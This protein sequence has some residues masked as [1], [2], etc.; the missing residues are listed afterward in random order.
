MHLDSA[1]VYSLIPALCVTACSEQHNTGADLLDSPLFLQNTQISHQCFDPAMCL[2]GRSDMW[3]SC[4]LSLHTFF[5]PDA[6][7]VL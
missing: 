2:P 7:A 5:F 1:G 4:R 3:S 6:S